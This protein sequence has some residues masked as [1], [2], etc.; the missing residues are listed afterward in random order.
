M[1]HCVCVC[2]YVWGGGGEGERREGGRGRG[3]W[4]EGEEEGGERGDKEM[5][6][7]HK[8]KAYVQRILVSG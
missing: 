8:D 3:G 1:L 4:G 7:V 5:I 6:E 2:V